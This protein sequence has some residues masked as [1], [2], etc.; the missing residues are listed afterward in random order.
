MAVTDKTCSVC[1][2]A[3]YRTCGCP[4]AKAFEQWPSSLIGKIRGLTGSGSGA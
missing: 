1:N 3:N 4:W 2:A